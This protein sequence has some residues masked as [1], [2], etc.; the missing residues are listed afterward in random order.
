MTNTERDLELTFALAAMKE[1]LAGRRA[2]N[3][4][5]LLDLIEYRTERIIEDLRLPLKKGA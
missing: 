3:N 1:A 5:D 4:R 2:E